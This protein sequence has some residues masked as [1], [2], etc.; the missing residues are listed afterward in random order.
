MYDA[1][2]RL[3]PPISVPQS[4]LA[5]LIHFTLSFKFSVRIFYVINQFALEFASF[6]EHLNA[7]KYNPTNKMIFRLFQNCFTFADM[8]FYFSDF[9]FSQRYMH[10]NSLVP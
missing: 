5:L 8:I 1:T 3:H 10:S 7:F 4:T 6:M 9:H 2:R